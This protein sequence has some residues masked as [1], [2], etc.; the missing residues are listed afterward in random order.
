MLMMSPV[1]ATNQH[2]GCLSPTG[3]SSDVVGLETLPYDN[4]PIYTLLLLLHL[5]RLSCY[6]FKPWNLETL[7][8]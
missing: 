4:G 1:A 2:R 3:S 6:H 5:P 7:Q 8:T